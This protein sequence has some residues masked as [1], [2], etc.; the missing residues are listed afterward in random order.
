M[1]EDAEAVIESSMDALVADDPERATLLGREAVNAVAEI[2]ARA[3]Q[4]DDGLRELEPAEAQWLG[5]TVDSLSRSADDGR[6]IAENA[7]Q[8]AAPG[9]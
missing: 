3:R 1:H 2:D 6:N 4:I 7:L 5:S 9:P 8:K